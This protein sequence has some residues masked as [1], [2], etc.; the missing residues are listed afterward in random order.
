MNHGVQPREMSRWIP[1]ALFGLAVGV[2][3]IT[4]WGGFAYDDFGIIV[5]DE[6]IHSPEQWHELWTHSYWDRP[7]GH[8][9]SNW[10]PL[11][12]TTYALN[13][14]VAGDVPWSYHLINTLLHGAVTLALFSLTLEILGVLG[15]ALIAASL[16]AVHPLHA[17]AVANVVGRAELMAALFA[18][19]AWQAHRHGQP[20]RA[21]LFFGLGVFSKESV[22]PIVG[23][24]VLDD[25]LGRPGSPVPPRRGS[26]PWLGLAGVIA[27]YFPARWAV[28][29]SLG[30]NRGILPLAVLNPLIADGL[31]SLARLATATKMLGFQWWLFIWPRHLSADYSWPQIP[32]SSNFLD[33]PAAIS[34]LL[35]VGLA[36]IAVRAWRRRPTVT[37][38]IGL[39]FITVFLTSNLVITVG[40]LF[41]E[42]LMY[43][44][45]VGMC[46]LVGV[47][48]AS[49]PSTVR[50]RRA[51]VVVS[52]VSLIA[53]GARTVRRSWDWRDT[54]HLWEHDVRVVP[55]ACQAWACL[56]VE[57]LARGQLEEARMM[58]RRALALSHFPGDPED[59]PRHPSALAKITGVLMQLAQ[60]AE[61]DGDL[62]RRDELLAEADL[63]TEQCLRMEPHNAEVLS[64]RAI[65]LFMQG[66]REQAEEMFE[67][68]L[69]AD[70]TNPIVLCNHGNH[71]WF[72]GRHQEA[73]T[74]LEQVLALAP[75][76]SRPH[77]I[78]AMIH[79]DLGDQ[80]ASER[81]RRA[82][83]EAVDRLPGW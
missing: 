58:L 38:A 69:A 64:F 49:I 74:T 41:A 2:Y 55:N 51:L 46:L 19:L 42:R 10:R 23:V 13:W 21:A 35:L 5:Q 59:I 60:R 62:R 80:E 39:W 33:P 63:A 50:A 72:T 40:V 76:S 83:Q 26:R 1:W 47:I 66:E 73:I 65:R 31:P 15:P 25:L 12:S 29:G 44:P 18:L 48:V 20:L 43:L 81:H 36:V 45:S 6:R 71:L 70:N 61:A 34:L 37:L 7:R 14:S 28:L 22:L 79:A 9:L 54:L 24:M 56:G 8:N 27:L 16:F 30:G 68:A 77:E 3:A 52:A 82:A 11:A 75:R 57:N 78:L 53:L 17:E 32:Y 4:W 67:R